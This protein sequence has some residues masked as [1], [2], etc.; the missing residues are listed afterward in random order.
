MKWLK[1]SILTL[2]IVFFAL[3]ISF[4]ILRVPQLWFLSPPEKF[5]L[6]L[7]EVL[8]VSCCESAADVSMV[9]SLL[10]GLLFSLIITF[11]MKAI[12]PKCRKW[13]AKHVS[14]C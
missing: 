5:W 13:L 3:A 1:S 9:V 11:A 7:Y 10:Y 6:Y 4:L 2:W 12:L 14:G 8:E